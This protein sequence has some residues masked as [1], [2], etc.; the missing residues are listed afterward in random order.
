MPVVRIRK[1]GMG[2]A[3]SHM[4]VRMP[5]AHAVGHRLLVLVR[6]VRIVAMHVFVLMFE[7]R[8]GVFMLMPL[9]QVQYH[10]NQ[11]QQPT[12]QQRRG[13]WLAQ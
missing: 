8:M 1:M 7:R 13:D 5:M 10:A 9:G 4:T 6:M 11:H 2:V 12:K 3:Q